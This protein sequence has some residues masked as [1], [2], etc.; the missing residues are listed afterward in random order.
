MKVVENLITMRNEIRESYVAIGNFDGVHYGHKILIKEMVEKAK[1]ENKLSVVFTFL[2]HPM[3][4]IKKD[5]KS[6]FGY[7]NNNEEKLILLESL[8]VD[9]V[10]TQ[11][12]NAEIANYSPRKFVELLK[13]KLNTE[14][15]FVGFNFTFGK[16][17]AGNT[18]D[19][20]HLG[21][22]FKITIN[23]YG[24]V[25]MDNEVVSSTLIRKNILSGNFDK[26]IKLLDHPLL[27]VGEVVEGK[28]IARQLGF[29]TANINVSN[30]LYP[31]FGIYG[32]VLQI[33][34]LDSE[35]LFG[36]VNVGI[37][38]TLKPGELCL[39]VHILDFDKYIYGHKIYLQLIEFMREERKFDS[40]I[41]LKETIKYDVDRWYYFKSEM[42]GNG[43]IFKIR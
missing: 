40:I 28:K 29:P 4:S 39:E 42:N 2:N 15:I 33:D 24:P 20:K 7:I 19:L 27:V 22:E 36:V 32:A 17:G 8:G 5:A 43:D 13:I 16:G 26:V 35:V 34:S 10:I 21:K 1:K 23:E 12:F 31:P 37:N 41:E 25:V 38:P 11:K 30:R 18:K 3:E 6:N 9:V 14:E